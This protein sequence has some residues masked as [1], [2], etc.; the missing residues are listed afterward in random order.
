MWVVQFENGEVQRE[1]DFPYWDKVPQDK[2]IR[3]ITILMP[4]GYDVIVSGYDK[5]YVARKGV[6]ELGSE[7]MRFVGYF[8]IGCLEKKKTAMAWDFDVR[9]GVD[10]ARPGVISFPLTEQELAE[11]PEEAFRPGVRLGE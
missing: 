11:Y 3:S 2:K 8:I 9:Y 7:K 10:N 4:F 1:P 5:Y 6:G